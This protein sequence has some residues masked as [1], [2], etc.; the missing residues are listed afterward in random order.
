MIHWRNHDLERAAYHMWERDGW[1]E[2]CHDRHYREACATTNTVGTHWDGTVN[3]VPTFTITH[4]ASGFVLAMPGSTV[5]IHHTWADAATA[6][7]NYLVTG[8]DVDW[9]E[10]RRRL[11]LAV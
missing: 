9:Y 5:S 6:A 3:G 1:P 11:R 2:D 10:D 4:T 7:E 8:A